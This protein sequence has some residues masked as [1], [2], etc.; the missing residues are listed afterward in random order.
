MANSLA[1]AD[2]ITARTVAQLIGQPRLDAVWDEECARTS[3]RRHRTR[4][5]QVPKQ[6]KSSIFPCSDLLSVVTK[7]LNECRQVYLA[8]HRITALVKK[9]VARLEA[10]AEK[11][12]CNREKLFPQSERG[13]PQHSGPWRCAAAHRAAP[14]RYRVC[15]AGRQPQLRSIDPLILPARFALPCHTACEPGGFRRELRHSIRDELCAPASIAPCFPRHA[16]RAEPIHCRAQDPWD[17]PTTG[18]QDVLRLFPFPITRSSAVAR[19]L[20]RGRCP[21]LAFIAR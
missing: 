21:G 10:Q 16:L 3:R 9:E 14:H 19:A 18:A 20:R 11:R 4:E 1:S 5:G 17:H 12:R 7:L 13:S 6:F 15:D 8:R 2:D